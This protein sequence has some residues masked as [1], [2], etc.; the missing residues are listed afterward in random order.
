VDVGFDKFASTL[1][2]RALVG[3]VLYKV[4]DVPDADAANRTMDD[5]RTYRN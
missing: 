4:A 2:R 5:V 3:G 1:K